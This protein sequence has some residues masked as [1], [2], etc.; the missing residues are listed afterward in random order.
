MENKKTKKIQ[1]KIHGMHCA[2]CEVLIERK[3]KKIPGVE[4][5]EVRHTTGRAELF[6]SRENLKLHELQDAIKDDGYSVTFCEDRHESPEAAKHQN[7]AEDYTQIGAMFLFVMA[8]YLTLEQFNLIPAGL[9]LTDNMSYGFIFLIGL[10]AATST[11]LAVSGGLL[12]TA[13]AKYSE[14]RPNLTGYQKFKPTLYFNIGRVVS[15][16]I[17]GGLIGALGSAIS[18]SARGTGIL[19]ILASLVMIILGFQMLNL[20]PWMRHFQPRMPKSIAH[21]IHDLSG[22]DGQTGAFTLGALT[23]FL[24]C[25]FTQ[26]LQ[27]YVLA[28]GNFAVGAFTMLAFSLGTL[29]MLLSLGAI[30]SF[31]KGSFQKQFLRFSAVLVILLGFWNI[32]N[33]LALA[34]LNINLSSFA[35]NNSQIAAAPTL[36]IVDGKQ[37]AKMR[38][39]GYSYYPSRFT[40][41]AGIPVEWRIDASRAAGCAQVITAPA[42]GLTRYLSPQNITTITFTPSE[43]GTI[44]FSCA[45]GMTTRGAAFKVIPRISDAPI[46]AIDENQDKTE[47][48]SSDCNPKIASCIPT[49]N[50]KFDMEIS[51]ERGFYPNSFTIKKGVS[52]EITINDKTPLGGCMSVMVIPQYDVTLPLKLGINLLAFKPTETGTIYATCSMGNRMIQFNVID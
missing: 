24:P 41:Q 47:Q 27:L 51:R 13:A 6:S 40:V 7:T 4:K 48:P 1:L 30:S 34:G 17:F 33:G 11:C 52:V 46:T 35:S 28:K 10:V 19:S 21:K 42:I 9:G 5:V 14:M 26:A 3:L 50:Q 15:Y 38:V 45:M 43:V 18:L 12:L 29:P 44:P 39:D 37:V 20:F 32:N 22:R 2:S 49:L 23:F 25:G 36:A 31:A 16:T 8:L